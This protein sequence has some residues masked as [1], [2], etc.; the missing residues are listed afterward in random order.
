MKMSERPS[1]ITRCAL[2][3]NDTLECLKRTIRSSFKSLCLVSN[4]NASCLNIL[5]A[6]P[7]QM[8]QTQKDVF[9]RSVLLSLQPPTQLRHQPPGSL[10]RA[11]PP[12]RCSATAPS[13]WFAP[14]HG[15]SAMACKMTRG[16]MVMVDGGERCLC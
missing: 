11:D 1:L 9:H 15:R 5:N 3:Q 14:R 4:S 16:G 13:S 8:P 10:P 12:R 2:A 7:S 6:T